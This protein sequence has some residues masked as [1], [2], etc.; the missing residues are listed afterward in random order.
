MRVL[1]AIFLTVLISASP[2]HSGGDSAAADATERGRSLARIL[3]V[4]LLPTREEAGMERTLL[5]LLDPTDSLRTADFATEFESALKRNADKLED[6]RIAVARVGDKA[7]PVCPPTADFTLAAKAAARIVS[8]PVKS[9][10]NVYYEVRRMVGALSGTRGKRIVL[11]TLENGDAEDD[12]EATVNALRRAGVRLTVVARE[13]YLSDTYWISSAT[14]APRGLTLRGG[15]AGFVEVPW[16]WLFQQAVAN[17]TVPSGFATF[18]L[19]RIAAATG[20]RVFLF[21]PPSS[22][23]HRCAIYGSCPFCNNDHAPTNRSYQSHRLRALA[24]YSGSRREAMAA[25]GK[26]PYFSAVLI[27]WGKAARAGLLRS[28]PSVKRAG[29]GLRAEKR[30]IGNGANLTGSLSFSSHAKKA[31]KLAVIAGRL[32]ADLETA[33]GLAKEAGG[34]R[35]YQAVADYTRVMLLLTRVNLLA[36]AAFC[37]EEG[38]VMLGRRGREV[39]PPEAPYYPGDPNFVGIGISSMSLCHGIGFFREMHLPGGAPFKQELA[40]LDTQLDG[41]LSRNEHS[42]FALAVYQSGIARFLLTVRGKYVPPPPRRR[43]DS[44]TDETATER[45]TR[46]GGGGDSSGGPASGGD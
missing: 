17:Q 31:D 21:Y 40:I 36:L 26:D 8:S 2:A 10:H 20:G 16:G 32:A 6:T 33:M 38:P 5:F 9:I 18:G 44:E 24:P 39:L 46:A 43:P 1:P 14:R 11:V 42:P 41:Y 13:A 25:A 12:L 28:R 35:R 45:P 22:S 23:G 30:Q 15:E 7:G 34:S 4:L 29:S 3:D 37:R 27:A 19:T